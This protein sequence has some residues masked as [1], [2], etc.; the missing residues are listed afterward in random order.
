MRIRRA[1]SAVALSAAMA[2]AFLA[3]SSGS[4]SAD[5]SDCKSGWVCLWDYPGYDGAAWSAASGPGYYTVGSKVQGKVSSIW[6]NSSRTVYLWS[7]CD[8]YIVLGPGASVYDLS[9]YNCGGTVYNT[10]NNRTDSLDI[11]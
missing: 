4:A 10:W 9:D 3:G 8:N 11:V 2:A 5:S 6:N 7:E 1:F